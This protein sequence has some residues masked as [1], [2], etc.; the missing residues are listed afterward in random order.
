MGM[1][2]FFGVMEEVIEGIGKKAN[3]MEKEFIQDQIRLN[4]KANG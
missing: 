2:N 3:S 4:R 1:A